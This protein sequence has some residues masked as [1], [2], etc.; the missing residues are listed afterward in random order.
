MYGIMSSEGKYLGEIENNFANLI[1]KSSKV[2]YKIPRDKVGL[3]TGFKI[4][5]PKVLGIQGKR[6]CV[7]SGSVFYI[8]KEV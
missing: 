4:S 7:P 2:S 1:R 3:T 8:L 6:V 5:E